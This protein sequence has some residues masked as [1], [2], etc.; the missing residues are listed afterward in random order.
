M[1]Q[2]VSIVAASALISAALVGGLTAANG[3][4][5]GTASEPAAWSNPPSGAAAC[6]AQCQALAKAPKV[7]MIPIDG[8]AWPA[9]GE[10]A[11]TF[12]A[13]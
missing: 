5:A 11:A 9:G 13:R 4:Q 7:R 10:T 6:K 8:R 1:K 3:T 12:V 2:L